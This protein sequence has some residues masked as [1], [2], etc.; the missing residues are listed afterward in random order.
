[1][2][3]ESHT[4]L[5][6]IEMSINGQG[7]FTSPNATISASNSY[8]TSTSNAIS[9]LKQELDALDAIMANGNHTNSESVNKEMPQN[10]DPPNIDSPFPQNNTPLISHSASPNPRPHTNPRLTL[11]DGL[12]GPSPYP[13]KNAPHLISPVASPTTS[14]T[15]N[16]SVNVLV[17]A[18][19]GSSYNGVTHEAD[20]DPSSPVM[21]TP[22]LT[23]TPIAQQDELQYYPGFVTSI[24][25][26]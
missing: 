7:L 9:E 20:L 18:I 12:D 5:D 10:F 8:D 23:P 16:N 4:T 3:A 26:P 1:M 2:F 24:E 25:Y 11:C 21:V 6:M 19:L 14:P 22:C 15:N 17:H 13:L